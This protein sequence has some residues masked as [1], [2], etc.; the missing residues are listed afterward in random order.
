LLIFSIIADEEPILKILDIEG[1]NE[2]NATN[3]IPIG[4]KL[5]TFLQKTLS[6]GDKL[7]TF[8]KE[9]LIV[10]CKINLFNK[11]K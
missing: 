8:L 6:F 5:S 3:L 11:I 1:F 9:I 10:N 7:S 2:K 4:D